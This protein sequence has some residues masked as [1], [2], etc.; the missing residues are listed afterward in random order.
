[1][2]E[3]EAELRQLKTHYEHIVPIVIGNVGYLMNIEDRSN[4]ESSY[5][6]IFLLVDQKMHMQ[7]DR[8][9]P[10]DNGDFAIIRWREKIDEDH[11][12]IE[13]L[14]RFI[15]VHNYQT[16]GPL[17]IRKIVDGIISN[18]PEEWHKEIRIKVN[19][20]TLY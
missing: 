13:K 18:Q 5:D 15:K 2:N 11:K 8:M 17:Y 14:L 7:M 4:K 10:I 20:L 16:E 12:Y 9:T 19:Q 3:I 1:L 6:G